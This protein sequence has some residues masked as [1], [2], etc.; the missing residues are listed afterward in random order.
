MLINLVELFPSYQGEGPD[1]GRRVLIT[2][3]KKCNRSCPWCDT[4]QKMNAH[5][6]Q[7]YDLSEIQQL[8]SDFK[9]GLMITGGEPTF[10]DNYEQ[11]IFL[12]TNLYF[13]FANVESNGFFLPELIQRV[14]LEKRYL[15]KYIKYIYSPKLFTNEDYEEAVITSE[16]IIEDHQVYLKM[17]CS[18][19][20][21]ENNIKLLNFL[22]F[23]HTDRIYLMPEGTTEKQLKENSEM[24][25][26]L[27]N[28]YHCNFTSRYHIT[29][30]FA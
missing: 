30:D 6:G 2:R 24:T 16:K 3:F 22:G 19:L 29:Y 18:K 25:L 28:R 21:Y 20:T 8:I 17:V 5:P 1:A 26:D 10:S 9:T 23:S 13:P 27:A 4:V 14:N 7:D 15:T 12:L 11:T